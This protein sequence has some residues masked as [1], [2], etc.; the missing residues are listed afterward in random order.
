MGRIFQT[1]WTTVLDME[2]TTKSTPKKNQ[3]RSPLRYPGSKRRFIGYIERA[4]EINQIK[5]SLYIEPFIGGGSIALQLLQDNFVD[6]AILMDIAWVNI[7][8]DCIIYKI[9]LK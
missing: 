7:H 1:D 5:P 8:Q 2:F 4:L 6:Y 9:I 3:V